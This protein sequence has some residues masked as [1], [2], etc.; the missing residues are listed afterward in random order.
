VQ[1]KMGS[2]QHNSSEPIGLK[3][4]VS[5]KVRC[6][7]LQATLAAMLRPATP[8]EVSSWEKHHPDI[9]NGTIVRSLKEGMTATEVEQILCTPERTAVKTSCLLS[10]F[11]FHEPSI[12]TVRSPGFVRIK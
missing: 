6:E 1:R 8:D 11:F 4:E 3:L 10:A 7:T 2:F 12:S 9:V 5:P